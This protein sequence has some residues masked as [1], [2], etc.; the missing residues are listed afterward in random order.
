MWNCVGCGVC[1]VWFGFCCC[2]DYLE[3]QLIVLWFVIFDL[4]DFVY[5]F[6]FRFGIACCLVF[7]LV[8]KFGVRVFDVRV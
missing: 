6:D 4:Y 8:W 1:C 2:F 5:S 7:G 3:I